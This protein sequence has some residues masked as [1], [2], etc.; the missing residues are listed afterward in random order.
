MARKARADLGERFVLSKDFVD[1]L[2]LYLVRVVLRRC[3]RASRLVLPTSGHLKQGLSP[4]CAL[5]TPV[6]DIGSF[7]LSLSL[8][9]ARTESE[10]TI[11]SE[12]GPLQL[13]L[14][15]SH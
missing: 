8:S 10:N 13:T 2:V 9:Q 7:T 4:G 15:Q 1:V 3:R 12:P 6:M 5:D 11:L 14:S